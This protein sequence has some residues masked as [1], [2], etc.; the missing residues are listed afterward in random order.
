MAKINKLFVV[1]TTKNI[2]NAGTDADFQLYIHRFGAKPLALIF[3]DLPYNERERGRTD[4]YRF[5]VSRKSIY[6]ERS[7]RIYMTMLNSSDGWLPESI[8]LIGETSTGESV[9]LGSHPD[10]PSDLWFDT[11]EPGSQAGHLIAYT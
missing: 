2:A 7:L 1:H 4:F 11:N 5:N 3:P 8:F 9:V 10:W 6:T